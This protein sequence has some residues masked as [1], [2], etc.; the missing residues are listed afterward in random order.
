[1]FLILIITSEIV[2]GSSELLIVIVTTIP[3][4]VVVN[5]TNGMYPREHSDATRVEERF[6]RFN[7]GI[8]IS[9]QALLKG[10]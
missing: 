1:M 8:I 9:N 5:T 2:L 4:L 6:V 10:V 7:C 3:L